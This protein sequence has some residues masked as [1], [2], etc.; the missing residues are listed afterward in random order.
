MILAYDKSDVVLSIFF[1][2]I[3]FTYPVCVI[4]GLICSIVSYWFCEEFSGRRLRPGE[5]LRKREKRLYRRERWRK[6]L[7]SVSQLKKMCE[8]V[9]I[10][11]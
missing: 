5:K 4:V 9:G 7:R 1:A 6:Y 11:W 3:F 2:C 8:D 10:S